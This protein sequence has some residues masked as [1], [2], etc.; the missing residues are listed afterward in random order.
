MIIQY[1]ELLATKVKMYQRGK[2]MVKHGEDLHGLLMMK[3]CDAQLNRVRDMT[4]FKNT[5]PCLTLP[6][7]DSPLKELRHGLCISK[8]LA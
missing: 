6:D 8:N 5:L 7:T 4:P 2:R 3:F 1:S